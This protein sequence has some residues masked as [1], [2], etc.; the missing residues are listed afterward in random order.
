MGKLL[1]KNIKE[2]VQVEFES[3]DKV[4]GVDMKSLPTIK[5]AW[6]AI[7]NE[8]IVGFG[9]MDDFPEIVDWNN[10]QIID[11]TGQMVFP[12]FCDSHTHLVY[13]SSREEEFVDRI[14]GLSYEEIAK[15]GGGILN[16]AKKL[17]RC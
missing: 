3:K 10:L 8:E 16:S 13:A 4:V 9:G 11:A 5:D 14:N 2:L 15:K 17:E 7:E 1:I 6:L 12:S